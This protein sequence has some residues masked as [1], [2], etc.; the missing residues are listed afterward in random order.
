MLIVFLDKKKRLD[1]DQRLTAMVN[2]ANA[3]PTPGLLRTPLLGK[4]GAMVLSGFREDELATAQRK[5]QARE[6]SNVRIYNI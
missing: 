6:I 1:V 3:P 4:I 5:W 2:S